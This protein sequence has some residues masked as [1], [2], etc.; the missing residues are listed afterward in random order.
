MK[1]DLHK[2]VGIYFKSNLDISTSLSIINLNNIIKT[3]INDISNNL[4]IEDD[5]LYNINCNLINLNDNISNELNISDDYL[6]INWINKNTNINR[7]EYAN[8]NLNTLNVI[9]R[10]NKNTLENNENINLY[11]TKSFELNYNNEKLIVI[12]FNIF[13]SPISNITQFIPIHHPEIP[14]IRVSDI[15]T[16][17]TQSIINNDFSISVGGINYRKSDPDFTLINTN[18]NNIINTNINFKYL[19][20]NNNLLNLA[21]IQ[22]NK[23]SS[24]QKS[25]K[26]VVAN[27]YGI[28]ND[29]T[30][31]QF[32]NNGL[33]SLLSLIHI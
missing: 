22:A 21:K 28:F 5:D 30:D 3:D 24:G 8:L 9:S 20:S 18:T 25:I 14:I 26:F 12:F 29:S 6:V 23:T 27:D 10:K 16:N 1:E 19:D 4:T 13:D 15:D 31:I 17:D 32:L 7:V 2:V 33:S 11:N